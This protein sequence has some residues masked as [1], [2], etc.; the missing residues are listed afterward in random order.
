MGNSQA[1]IVAFHSDDWPV[2]HRYRAH[3]AGHG[4][5][6]SANEVLFEATSIV[7]E[8]APFF[9]VYGDNLC[10]TAHKREGGKGYQRGVPRLSAARSP[11]RGPTVADEPSIEDR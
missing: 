2:V 6:A 10:G 11:L 4:S 1:A 5:L 9:F 7:P 8:C 3:A